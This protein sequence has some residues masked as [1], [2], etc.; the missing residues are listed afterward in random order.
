MGSLSRPRL[1]LRLARAGEADTIA[2][3]S[4]RE[5]EAGLAAWSWHG[6]R[7]LA[8]IRDDET[9]VLVAAL[10]QRIVGFAIM[11]FGTRTAHLHLMAVEPEYRRCGIG[12]QLLGWLTQ[13]ARTAGITR[14]M[15][16][17]RERNTGAQSFYA[18]VGYEL[19]E[20]MPGYYGGVESALRLVRDLTPETAGRT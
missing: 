13:S 3:V 2:A 14:L 5:I 9:L 18:S 7:V 11:R 17:V 15:L 19:F 10:D 20:R 12:R 4:R 1:E 6:E 8:S 16:E